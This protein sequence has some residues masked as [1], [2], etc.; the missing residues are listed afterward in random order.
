[1]GERQR[2][3]EG[4]NLLLAIGYLV[5]VICRRFHFPLDFVHL[6]FRFIE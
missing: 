6:S 1:M 2:G 5:L 3:Q 4:E